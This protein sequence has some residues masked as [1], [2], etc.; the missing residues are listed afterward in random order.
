MLALTPHSAS[1]YELVPLFLVPATRI[2]TLFLALMT[3]PAEVL[4]GYAGDARSAVDYVTNHAHWYL[5]FVYLPALLMVLRRRN[6]GE[7]PG[8]LERRVDHLP[9]WIRGTSVTSPDR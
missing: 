9:L 5:A 7:V 3:W 4:G 6:I 8:W 2:E 1:A